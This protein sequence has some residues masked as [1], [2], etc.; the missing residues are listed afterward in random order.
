MVLSECRILLVD[1][2][3]KILDL[4]EKLLRENGF[5]NVFTATGGYE[6]ELI[7]DNE[8]IDLVVLDI[9]MPEID[10]LSLYESWQKRGETIPVIFLSA[11]D[12]EAS[13]L[14]GLGLGADD[15]VTKPYTPEELLL[16][17]KAV[18]RRTYH[19]RENKVVELGS[20]KVDLSSGIVKRPDGD[21]ELT[22][23]E[24]LLF[25]KLYDNQGKIVSLNI[26][27]DTLWPDGSYGLENSL[28]VHIRRLREKI[29]EDPSKPTHLQ[30]VRGLGYRLNIGG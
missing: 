26:L 7:K 8:K 22:A 4:N 27:M 1:D 2:E 17:I 13:R 23:K 15:Y 21:V 6:A 29:E 5:N 14:K 11:R 9:M 24:F 16:R 19:L 30:T 25:S 18:L 12:E 20:V 10:G 3:K 28:I